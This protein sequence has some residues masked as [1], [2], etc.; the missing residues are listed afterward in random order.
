VLLASLPPDE[1]AGVLSR[2][3]FEP[4]TDSTILER[5]ALE[6]ELE[7]VREQ[8]WSIVDQELEAGLRAV[9]APVRDRRGFVVGAMTLVAQ[10]AAS[11]VR[12][13]A[14]LL[15]PQLLSACA[16]IERDLAAG[17]PRL[18]WTTGPGILR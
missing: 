14:P 11:P 6:A 16:A 10:G 4:Y 9:G 12:D 2:T 15:V 3:E 17:D 18:S 8:G 13:L 5:A 7:R 1:L